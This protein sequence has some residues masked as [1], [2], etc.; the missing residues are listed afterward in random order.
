MLCCLS[1]SLWHSLERR[2]MAGY[3]ASWVWW[4]K[5][6]KLLEALYTSTMSTVRVDGE[7]TSWFKTLVSVLQGCI[8]SHYFSTSFAGCHCSGDDGRK[9]RRENFWSKVIQPAFRQRHWSAIKDQIWP[10]K[11]SPQCRQH[12]QQIWS[13]GK[14]HENRN[15]TCG[16]SWATNKWNARV[17]FTYQIEW[18]CLVGWNFGKWCNMR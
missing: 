3:A 10:S 16:A 15:A 5:I 8:L 7:L 4:R 18:I 2:L 12:Q 1:K 17:N 14:L 13:V 9:D 11:S 6:I